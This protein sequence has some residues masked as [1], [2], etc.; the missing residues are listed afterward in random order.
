MSFTL[1][2]YSADYFRFFAK[3]TRNAIKFVNFAFP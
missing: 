1:L 2:R 3:T